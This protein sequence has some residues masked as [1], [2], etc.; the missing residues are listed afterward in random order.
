[1]NR[2]PN[3]M[4]VEILN[5]P[6]KFFL[7]NQIVCLFNLPIPKEKCE[8]R[9]AKEEEDVKSIVKELTA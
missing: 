6:H 7:Q 8:F 3:K 4:S 9:I 2:K 1:M 5:C